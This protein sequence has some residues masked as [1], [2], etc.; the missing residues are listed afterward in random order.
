MNR[1]SVVLAAALTAT[2]ASSVTATYALVAAQDPKPDSGVVPTRRD[3]ADR[4]D[5]P[6]PIRLSQDT[7]LVFTGQTSRGDYTAVF[8]TRV[9][10]EWR[11]I[12]V[13]PP[14]GIHRAQPIR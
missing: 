10:G 11:R 4:A 3:P 7:R 2:A 5:L 14:D 9:N 1:R 8:E 12:Y 13:E 6:R